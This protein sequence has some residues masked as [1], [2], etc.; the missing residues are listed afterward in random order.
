MLLILLVVG[1][2]I[3]NL[4]SPSLSKNP[5]P[6]GGPKTTAAISQTQPP[7]RANIFDS[8]VELT[9]VSNSPVTIQDITIN[10]RP[11]CTNVDIKAQEQTIEN[12]IK[13]DQELLRT[14]VDPAFAL[15]VG[16]QWFIQ[17][18]EFRRVPQHP[19]PIAPRPMVRF[20][21]ICGAKNHGREILW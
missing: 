9:N 17:I 3:L 15:D 7:L 2:Y 19:R 1:V 14:F 18:L 12:A 21:A 10:N 6:S 8:V 4:S 5:E 11:E 13:A 16:S 20:F